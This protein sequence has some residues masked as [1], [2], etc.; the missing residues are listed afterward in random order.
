MKDDLDQITERVTEAQRKLNAAFM[1]IGGALVCYQNNRYT[2]GG[3]CA[4]SA[5]T[6]LLDASLALG[7][8]QESL[9][10]LPKGKPQ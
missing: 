5:S 10:C 9:L 6:L 8:A 1:W 3:K 2:E 7:S 4:E